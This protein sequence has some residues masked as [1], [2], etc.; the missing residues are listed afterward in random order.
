ME[1]KFHLTVRSPTHP[2][3]RALNLD[4]LDGLLDALQQ[5][6]VLW[7]LVALLV[8]VHVSQRVHVRIKVL[9]TNGLLQSEKPNRSVSSRAGRES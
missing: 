9:L 6:L 7:V 3:R 1:G 4:A 5:V 8:G 2:H